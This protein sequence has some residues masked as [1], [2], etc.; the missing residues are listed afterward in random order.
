MQA[1]TFAV[2]A[3][4][5]AS[6][7][8]W[9]LMQF[10]VAIW[11]TWKLDNKRPSLLI[12]CVCVFVCVCVCAD[13]P[14]GMAQKSQPDP[15][16]A[17]S[18][19]VADVNY[20]DRYWECVKGEPKNFDCPNGLVFSGRKTQLLQF[21]HYPWMPTLGDVCEDKQ[22]ASKS[23]QRRPDALIR[24]RGH[25]WTDR[26]HRLWRADPPI[27]S[28]VCDWQYGVFGHEKSCIRYWSCWNGTASEQ[29]CPGGLLYNEESHDCDW[30]SQVT[31][32]QK[33][34]KLNNNNDTPTTPFFFF[35]DTQFHG[36]TQLCAPMTRPPW[37]RWASPATATGNAREATRVSS[38]ARP[39]SSSTAKLCAAST[40]RPR[41][42]TRRR[43]RLPRSRPR[44]ARRMSRKTTSTKSKL[45]AHDRASEENLRTS[46]HRHTHTPTHQHL[47]RPPHP[48]LRFS[49]AL[50]YC[51][52]FFFSKPN[53]HPLPTPK[54]SFLNST[55]THHS[56]II[57]IYDSYSAGKI[58]N[59][60]SSSSSRLSDLSMSET[61]PPQ[62]LPYPTTTCNPILMFPLSINGTRTWI[63][64]VVSTHYHPKQRTPAPKCCCKY[65]RR[66]K[67]HFDSFSLR[68]FQ[69]KEK[70]SRFP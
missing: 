42:A 6:G 55:S 44:S 33:H 38:S 26:W 70:A 63:R 43:R 14:T 12:A 20:C 54:K 52:T 65:K 68:L 40:R 18:K 1:L 41:T 66:K 69:Y 57:F 31:G 36:E 29:F 64:S 59:R 28:G 2:L 35:N 15:C 11:S 22:L 5:I 48:H 47:A 37:R 32:C 60:L 13:R 21:C 62:F 17:K 45:N 50:F 30:P 10:C 4:A 56:L 49:F 16:A 3:L 7:E 51:F 46:T 8:S 58:L 19:L 25:W 67:R 53:P 23:H 27:S 39:A 9:F 24:Q 61:P 34:R